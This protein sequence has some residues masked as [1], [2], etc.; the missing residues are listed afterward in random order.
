[1]EHIVIDTSKPLVHHFEDTVFAIGRFQALHRGHQHL[2]TELTARFPQK[3]CG[4][5]T[6][7][8]DPRDFF[9]DTVQQKVLTHE[10][11]LSKFEQLGIDVVVEFKFDRLFSNM[12]KIEFVTLLKKLGIETIIHGEDFR[13]GRLD[14]ERK[15]KN[16]MMQ[17]IHDIYVDGMK[18]SSTQLNR[19][20]QIGAIDQLNSA[21]NYPY[22]LSGVVTGGDQ[23]ARTLGFPTANLI[24]DAEKMLP[25]DGVYA[26]QTLYNGSV[27]Q[28]VTHI[29]P[30][31]TFHRE[32][33]KIETYVFNMDEDLYGETLTI[34]FYKRIRGVQVFSGVE[35]VKIQLQHDIEQVKQYFYQEN[36]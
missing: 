30:S 23:R 1:M 32:A 14:D 8:P 10:E 18:V 4:V 6:F 16:S 35:A 15:S 27:F 11:R 33:K 34:Q 26:T 28:S 7:F 5:L 22:F 36:I 24:V 9:S 12:T 2:L 19:Y 25:S 20:L 31:P 13:F 29:G 21:L 3:R 17:A